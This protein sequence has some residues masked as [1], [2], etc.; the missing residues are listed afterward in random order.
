MKITAEY[1]HRKWKSISYY[2][3]GYIQ[4]EV[5]HSLEWHVG[6]KEIDQK[7]L[8]IVSEKEPE[9]LQTSKSIAVSKSHTGKHKSTLE[10]LC[11][12]FFQYDTIISSIIRKEL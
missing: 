4:V 12:N 5:K 8:V 10:K 11:T 1:L 3:G 7:T 2:D 6:Y 9:L